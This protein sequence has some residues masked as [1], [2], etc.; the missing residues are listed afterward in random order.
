MSGPAPVFWSVSAAV[1]VPPAAAVAASA[2]GLHASAGAR[3]PSPE[4][5]TV[6]VGASGSFEVTVSVPLAGPVWPGANVTVPAVA[7]PGP[8][9]SGA[10]KSALKPAP[11]TATSVI[12]SVFAPVL[13]SVTSAR[14]ASPTTVGPKATAAGATSS[15]PS[16]VTVSESGTV[17]LPAPSSTIKS[18][19]KVPAVSPSAVNVIATSVASPGASGPPVG[20]AETRNGGR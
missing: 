19:V 5:G 8:S 15:C 17:R 6:R 4:R 10:A 13:R 3:M 1:A 20:A 18:L 2:F 7:S 11:L 14:S 9:V 16:P 12:W